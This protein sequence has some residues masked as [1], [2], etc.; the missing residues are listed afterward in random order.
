M[1]DSLYLLIKPANS[2]T[3][4]YTVCQLRS[5]LNVNCSSRYTVSGLAGGH[6]ESNCE[7]PHDSEAYYKSLLPDIAPVNNQ[8]DWRNIGSEWI[9]SLSLNTGTSNANSSTSRILSQLVVASTSA[10]PVLNNLMPSIAEHLAVMAGNTLMMASTDASFLHYW[11]YTAHIL[12]PGS[13]ETF[14]ASLST[15]QYTSGLSQRWQGIFYVVLLLVFVTNVFCLI[16]FFL[17]SGLVT[18]YT[19]TQNLFALAVNSPPSNRLHGSC[20]AGPQGDQLNV[21]WHV[22]AD[23]QSGHFFIKEGGTST[24]TQRPMKNYELRRRG[25]HKLQSFNSYNRLSSKT[26]TWL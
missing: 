17:F 8:P 3:T 9:Q 22:K 14:N 15:E 11:N 12:T 13:Y 1:S 21:D 26:G 7:D 23:D 4:D 19:E 18:D 25:S 5:Y 6:L 2:V 16:Y 24:G 20:G 10:T